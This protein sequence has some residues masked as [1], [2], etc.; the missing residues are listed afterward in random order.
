M[1][2]VVKKEDLRPRS[3]FTLIE[4]LVVIAII[5]V[6]ISL[7]LPAVQQ[8]REASRRT[9]SANRVRQLALAAHNFQ[10]TYRK[11]PQAM[12]PAKGVASGAP[13]RESVNV[14]LLPY[15]D[16]ATLLAQYQRDRWWLDR[17]AGPGGKSNLDWADTNV[18]IFRA[19]AQLYKP[20]AE[21]SPGSPTWSW[22]LGTDIPTPG[23]RGSSHSQNSY[24]P[25]KTNGPITIDLRKE[26]GGPP[27]GTDNIP[28]GSSN[29]FLLAPNRVEGMAL[30][31]RTAMLGM[32]PDPVNG[33]VDYSVCWP[34]PGAGPELVTCGGALGE[35]YGK[36]VKP[37][38]SDVE[39]PPSPGQPGGGQPLNQPMAFGPA[40]GHHALCDGSV[41]L[42][43][44]HVDKKLYAA[45][46]TISGSEVPSALDP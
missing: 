16:Q 34:A 10:S 18:S 33:G 15:I 39:P 43:S 35:Y 29:T 27:E 31:I 37:Q 24:L 5:A 12:R 45:M 4:L 30:A 26:E 1:K 46:Y 41:R 14:Q 25:Q 11:L 21:E 32:H 28:D 44:E 22:V 17:T 38:I 19:T 42:I 20:G 23:A 3:G 8:A 9:E 7:I 6:L 2:V 13:V 40:P 36:R